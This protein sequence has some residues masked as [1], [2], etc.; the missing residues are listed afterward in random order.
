MTKKR[1]IS[2][3]FSKPPYMIKYNQWGKEK[4]ILLL[5]GLAGAGK[6]YIA[7]RHFNRKVI[8]ISLDILKFYEQS[9]GFSKDLLDEF[10]NVFPEIKSSVKSHWAEIDNTHEQDKKYTEYTRIFFDFV[11][12]KCN[13]DKASLYIIEGI[14]MFARIPWI[15]S[16]D[17]PCII[18]RTSVLKSFFRAMLRYLKK[19]RKKKSFIQILIECKIHHLIQPPILNEY[20]H[21]LLKKSHQNLQSS[22]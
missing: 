16:L 2:F 18:L 21:Y 3:A 19:E 11:C 10:L 9:K 14:Q 13:T 6:T 17:Y 7:K 5:T 1:Y 4:N 22:K 15:K 8:V 12:E 20:I